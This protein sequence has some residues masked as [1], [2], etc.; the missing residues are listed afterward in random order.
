MVLMLACLLAVVLPPAIG[1][2][3]TA[4][5]EDQG[6]VDVELPPILAPMVVQNRL[7]GYAYITVALAPN[8]RDKVNAI[9]EKMPFL[10]DAFLREVN[11]TSVVKAEDPKAVD[12]A[13]VTARLTARMNQIL[14]QGTVTE[15]K[16]QQI[17]LAP[18]AS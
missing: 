12:A 17:V 6:P 8:G 3:A 9:R 5:T 10:Q 15:L 11:K 4:A 16:L 7:E 13:A 1:H 14:P 18:F 2:A